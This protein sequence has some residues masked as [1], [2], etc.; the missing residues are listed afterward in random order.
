MNY[1]MSQAFNMKDSIAK[2]RRHLHQN[3]ECGM[4][5]PNT[6]S[7]VEKRLNEI[8]LTPQKCG[9]SGI[10]AVLVG[11]KPG[12]NI[13]L[14]GDM[15]ALPMEE[16]NDLPFRTTTQAAHNCGHDFH[17]SMLLAAATL[18]KQKEDE[19]EGSVTFMFQP[20]EEIFQGARSM[21]D[22]GLMA[23]PDVD[24]AF[25]LHVMPDA[26]PGSLMFC[27]GNTMASCDGFEI[28]IKGKGCHGAM[29]Q[30]GYD[31]INVGVQI[32]QG[33]QHLIAR[34]SVPAETVTLTFGQFSAGVVNNIVP[35]VA[36]LK[37]T[38]RTFNQQVREIL[39]KRMKEITE[40]L[41]K[42]YLV[43]TTYTV[44]SDVAPTY[45][46]PELLNTMLGYIDEIGYDFKKTSN[47]RLPASDDM[48]IVAG[49]VPC[50]YMFLGSKTEGCPYPLHNP[51]VYYCWRNKSKEK[52]SEPPIGFGCSVSTGRFFNSCY[53]PYT[54]GRNR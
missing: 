10:K 13:L 6:T 8:G 7:Y 9:Q 26:A 38:L 41:A 39:L 18:L 21:I 30:L 12:K 1:F 27:E 45:N 54:Y 14:R 29:P 49:L 19:L 35:E 37:G 32:Y 22:A 50:I 46:N 24:A 44:L 53:S 43:E 42:A 33:F 47:Y 40:N 28:T 11:K 51:G 15:D 31:P 2:D 16:H 48:S 3:A 52:L 17:T 25:A 23:N 5:L 4:D 34:E 36:V 20:G